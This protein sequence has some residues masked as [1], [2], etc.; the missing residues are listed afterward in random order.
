[1]KVYGDEVNLKRVA[2]SGSVRACQLKSLQTHR[3]TL[4]CKKR[5]YASLPLSK[6]DSM[7]C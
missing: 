7:I 5:I 4:K 6:Y 2:A 3:N 1:M